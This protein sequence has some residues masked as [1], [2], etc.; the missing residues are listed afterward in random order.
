MIKACKLAVNVQDWNFNS[1][2]S[3]QSL[4]VETALNCW[5]TIVTVPVAAS[6]WSWFS[7]MLNL[8]NSSAEAKTSIAYVSAKATR[9]AWSLW[10]TEISFYM[11]GTNHISLF[12]NFSH[13]GTSDTSELFRQGVTQR[14]L[15]G[16]GGGQ[17]G[18]ADLFVNVKTIL[19]KLW[20]LTFWIW[21]KQNISVLALL[22]SFMQSVSFQTGLPQG[23]L[24]HFCSQAVYF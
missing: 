5:T 11:F 2:Q 9:L 8:Q 19:A 23:Q 17:E 7:A 15:L 24:N 20:D 16:M 10:K 14:R 21:R 12:P 3:T 1:V 6:V 13:S 22:I 18:F 4:L